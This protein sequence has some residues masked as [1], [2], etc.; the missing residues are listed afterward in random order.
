MTLDGNDT[1]HT[2]SAIDL[3][4]LGDAKF[5]GYPRR[6]PCPEKRSPSAWKSRNRIDRPV[7]EAH[8]TEIVSKANPPHH[9]H[10]RPD[11]SL[12]VTRKF[13][14]KVIKNFCFSKKT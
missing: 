9:T 13:A 2:S 1:E 10:N 3:S 5:R 14:R 8:L 11:P 12:W 7:A 4:S 6:L